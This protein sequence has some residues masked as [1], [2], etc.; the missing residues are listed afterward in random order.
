[1][2]RNSGSCSSDATDATK[3][4]RLHI[5]CAQVGACCTCRI[6][7]RADNGHKSGAHLSALLAHQALH[8]AH[9]PA[10]A[11][12]GTGLCCKLHWLCSR[13]EP[14]KRRARRRL[15]QRRNCSALRW[16]A[17]CFSCLDSGCVCSMVEQ[18]GQACPLLHRCCHHCCH[19]LA[20]K[21]Y[22]WTRQLRH[23]PLWQPIERCTCTQAELL[24]P[25]A[26]CLSQVH[27]SSAALPTVLH[28]SDRCELQFHVQNMAC[29]ASAAF[30]GRSRRTLSLT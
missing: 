5:H 16:L 11:L 20:T 25:I 28:H 27:A 15:Q 30:A 17:S 10:P 23:R 19:H 1:M 18:A 12:E 26:S 4:K 22:L 8:H 2:K 9:V 29:C 7:R 3:T 13:P 24:S 14:A 21:L 6:H